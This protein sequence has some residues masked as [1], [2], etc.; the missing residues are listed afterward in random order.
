M[1]QV[2]AAISSVCAAFDEH[3]RRFAE[4]GH[5][6]YTPIPPMIDIVRS[7]MAVVP[8]TSSST[9]AAAGNSDARVSFSTPPPLFPSSIGVQGTSI[10]DPSWL[11]SD[12][13]DPGD[14]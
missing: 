1:R 13:G 14:V 7:A 12:F 11:S 4:Y 9:A 5:L 2:E 3:M 6:W 8:S 10:V